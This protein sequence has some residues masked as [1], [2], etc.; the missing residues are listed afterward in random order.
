M[1]VIKKKKKNMLTKITAITFCIFIAESSWSGHND[2]G[3]ET[4]GTRDGHIHI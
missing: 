2:F 3:G 4:R 1:Y